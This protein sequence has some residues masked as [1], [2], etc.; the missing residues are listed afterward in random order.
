MD[1]FWTKSNNSMNTRS[2]DIELIDSLIESP[3]LHFVSHKLWYL[4]KLGYLVPIKDNYLTDEAIQI[5]HQLV[6]IVQIQL[7]EWDQK[8]ISTY[9]F[10]HGKEVVKCIIEKE[11]GSF[12][13]VLKEAT[14]GHIS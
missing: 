12:L 8:Q 14:N 11:K 7:W 5:S 3:S 13:S 10:E 2:N 4:F 9:T 6:L 1:G